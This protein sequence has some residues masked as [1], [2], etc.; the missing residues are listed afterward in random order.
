MH[1]L[2]IHRNRAS[3]CPAQHLRDQTRN[4]DVPADWLPRSG[5]DLGRQLQWDQ[6]RAWDGDDDG[7]LDDQEIAGFRDAGRLPGLAGCPAPAR[8]RR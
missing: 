3:A 8:L 5:S 6:V 7:H 4:Y 2:G 1:R